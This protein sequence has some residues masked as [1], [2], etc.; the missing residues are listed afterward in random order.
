MRYEALQAMAKSIRPTVPL[1]FVARTLGFVP[2]N[3]GEEDPTD[4]IHECEEW[5]RAH[6]GVVVEGGAL[7]AAFDAKVRVFSF[8]FCNLFVEGVFGFFY[9]SFGY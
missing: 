3:D 2:A 7:E 8:V 5:L 4:H 1:P 6:G 9:G